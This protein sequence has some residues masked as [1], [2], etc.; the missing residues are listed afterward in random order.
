[1][2]QFEKQKFLNAA[3]IALFSLFSLAVLTIQ[4]ATAR[5]AGAESSAAP[6]KLQTDNLVSP[7]GLDDLTPQFAWQLTDT[8]RGA[9]QNNPRLTAKRI[10]DAKK[11]DFPKTFRRRWLS[12]IHRSCLA[13]TT[14]VSRNPT[15][16]R[17][18][19]CFSRTS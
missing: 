3:A 1:M 18:R 4:P 12:R 6:V 15:A 5:A 14:V 2:Q 16:I 10:I 8:R 13:F 19:S 7:M 9:R 11:V 17:R